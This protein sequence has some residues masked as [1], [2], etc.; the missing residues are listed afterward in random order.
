MFNEHLKRIRIASGRTQGELA[1]CLNISTQSVSKWESGQSLP[2]IDILP[3]IAEFFKCPIN[4]FFSKYELEIHEH[5]CKNAPSNEDVTDLLI[6]IIS[7]FQDEID[8]K[9][10]VIIDEIPELTVPLEALLIPKV[11][12]IVENA[13][14]ITCSLLQK[15]L[16][17]GYALA[18]NIIDG[19]HNLGVLKRNPDTKMYEVQK[20]KIHN[21]EA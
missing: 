3:K 5:L 13:E 8:G 4:A 10:D 19:L 7:Q 17:V 1:S 14:I 11:Y 9:E 20:N 21:L 12:E 18:A 16:K 2:S 6:A 15:E